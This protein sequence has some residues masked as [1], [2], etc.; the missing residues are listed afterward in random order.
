LVSGER[1]DLILDEPGD[2]RVLVDGSLIE[3]FPTGRTARTV[4]AYPTEGS[5]WRLQGADLLTVT[6]LVLPAPA[7]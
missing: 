1:S 6:E 4:R 3:A 5:Y 7:G 2:V